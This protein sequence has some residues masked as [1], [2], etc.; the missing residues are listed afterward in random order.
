MHLKRRWRK[1]PDNE[2]AII[3]TAPE[4]EALT[5]TM[6]AKRMCAW[7]AAR[8]WVFEAPARRGEKPKVDRQYYLSKMSGQAAATGARAEPRLGLFGRK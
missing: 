6:Q 8:G 2:Q 5:G 4:L 1:M 7:L 3:L